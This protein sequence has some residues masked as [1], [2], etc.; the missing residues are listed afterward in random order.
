MKNEI[1]QDLIE[2]IADF[3][4]KG[5]VENIVVMFKRDPQLYA[6][7]GEL[8]KD[9]RY[10][11]RMGVAV[12]FEELATIKPKDMSRAIPALLPLLSEP[13][14]YIRGEACTIL[15]IINTAEAHHHLQAMRSD[16][17]QQVREITADILNGCQATPN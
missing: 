12:L 6:I 14:A 16:S 5:L 7:T 3:I 8:L 17:D 11:V 10:M 15:G 9:E 1:D 2:T 13:T 4:D